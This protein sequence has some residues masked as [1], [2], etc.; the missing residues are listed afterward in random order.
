MQVSHLL[1]GVACWASPLAAAQSTPSTWRARRSCRSTILTSSAGS[2]PV[3]PKDIAFKDEPHASLRPRWFNVW[4]KAVPAA[5]GAW[6]AAWTGI[7]LSGSVLEL[8]GVKLKLFDGIK[9]LIQAG[10]AIVSYGLSQLQPS[11]LSDFEL[12]KKA[13]WTWLPLLILIGCDLIGLKK[14]TEQAWKFG[15]GVF[16]FIGFIVCSSYAV[17]SSTLPPGR[18]TFRYFSVPLLSA[19]VSMHLAPQFIDL[20]YFWCW[21]F[22]THEGRSYGTQWKEYHHAIRDQRR[23]HKQS[24]RSAN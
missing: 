20:F 12:F 11:E 7:L 18:A 14:I 24:K 6:N 17:A 23:K 9:E 2:I 21:A 16:G 1:V 22:K 10:S 19:G 13:T 3:P 15:S 5:L 8:A 4:L